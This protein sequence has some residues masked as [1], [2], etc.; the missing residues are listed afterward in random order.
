MISWYGLSRIEKWDIL[1]P[2]SGNTEGE[3]HLPQPHPSSHAW[4]LA[5]QLVGL[6]GQAG[7][8]S[9]VLCIIP[10]TALV[11]S[12]PPVPGASGIPAAH[13]GSSY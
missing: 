2:S 7:S 12:A 11:F 3:S 6:Q 13:S 9:W 5:G 1:V 4:G 8:G 10:N